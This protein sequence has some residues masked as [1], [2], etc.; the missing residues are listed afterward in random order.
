MFNTVKGTQ[1][2][3]GSKIKFSAFLRE[4]SFLWM[5]KSLTAVISRIV[6]GEIPPYKDFHFRMVLETGIFFS[7]FPEVDR[8]IYLDDL[9]SFAKISEVLWLEVLCLRS[10]WVGLRMQL[11]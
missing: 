8:I 1:E 10:I 3:E 4:N 9:N 2:I 7:V 6:C 11:I 5:C